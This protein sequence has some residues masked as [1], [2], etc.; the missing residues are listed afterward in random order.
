M[1][2]G[3]AFIFRQSEIR[4]PHSAIAPAACRNAPRL[5]QWLLVLASLF[6]TER[7]VLPDLTD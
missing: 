7:Q 4:I 2:V 3:V 6:A 1:R 5:A